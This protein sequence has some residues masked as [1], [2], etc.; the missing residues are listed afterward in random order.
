[1]LRGAQRRSNLDASHQRA[2]DGGQAAMSSDSENG[3]R[4][5]LLVCCGQMGSA[6]LRGWLRGGAAR[7]FVVIEPAGL[8]PGPAPDGQTDSP[9]IKWHRT[10]EE[11]AADLAPDAVVFAVKP[12]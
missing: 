7:R 10:P 9:A 1:S 12:Q 8:P 3:A 4:T 2:R 11:A 5:I 6:M